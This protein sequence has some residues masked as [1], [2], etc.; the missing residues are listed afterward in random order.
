MTKNIGHLI[1]LN[2]VYLYSAAHGGMY[3]PLRVKE[4][5]TMK[6]QSAVAKQ[7]PNNQTS[8][9]LCVNT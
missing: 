8:L 2:D 6:V 3:A 4:S 9:E 1:A 5:A 7:S